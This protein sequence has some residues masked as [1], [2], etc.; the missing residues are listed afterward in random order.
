MHSN[1]LISGGGSLAVRKAREAHL[2]Y[3]GNTLSPLGINRR[4]EAHSVI[5]DTT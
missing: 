1:K 2:I 5:Y 4:D 3:K